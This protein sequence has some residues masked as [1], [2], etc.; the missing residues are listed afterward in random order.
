MEEDRRAGIYFPDARRFVPRDPKAEQQAAQ[1]LVA[2][3]FTPVRQISRPLFYDVAPKTLQVAVYALLAA[4]WHIEAEG[5]VYRP[6]GRPKMEVRS[7]L[8]WFGLHGHVAF[9]GHDVPLPKLL[10]ALNRGETLLT[11]ED[12]SVGLIPE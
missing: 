10:Q 7:G 8:D 3:G 5:K 12:G 1:A 6:P 9:A 4:G 2:L 11:L